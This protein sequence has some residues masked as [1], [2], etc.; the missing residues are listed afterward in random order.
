[1]EASPLESC[2]TSEVINNVP[3]VTEVRLKSCLIDQSAGAGNWAN[4]NATL[5]F[6]DALAFPTDVWTPGLF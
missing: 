6:A 5:T 2:V 4:A 1:M 3:G